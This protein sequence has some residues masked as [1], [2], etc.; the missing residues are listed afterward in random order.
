MNSPTQACI[1]RLASF[2]SEE[3]TLCHEFP[4]GAQYPAKS[5]AYLS[6]VLR[7]RQ[8]F[9]RRLRL[10]FVPL[11]FT[12]EQRALGIYHL[13]WSHTSTTVKLD[14]GATPWAHRGKKAAKG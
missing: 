12:E 7:L 9:S 11:N 1:K 10:Y 2:I 6:P 13:E 14:K 3:F 8:A 5:A 4:D